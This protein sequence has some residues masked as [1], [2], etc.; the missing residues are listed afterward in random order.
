[1]SIHGIIGQAIIKSAPGRSIIALPPGRIAPRIRYNGSQLPGPGICSTG[2]DL[3]PGHSGTARHFQR[4][5]CFINNNTIRHRHAT[6]HYHR[7]TTGLIRSIRAGRSAIYNFH[8]FRRTGRHARLLPF[9]HNHLISPLTAFRYSIRCHHLLAIQFLLFI[10]R[11][12]LIWLQQISL[13][14]N[15]LRHAQVSAALSAQSFQPLF[16]LNSALHLLQRSTGLGSSFRTIRYRPAQQSTADP[17]IPRSGQPPQ[18]PGRFR[19]RSPIHLAGT[20]LRASGH[21]QLRIAGPA[22]RLPLAQASSIAIHIRLPVYSARQSLPGIGFVCRQQFQACTVICRPATGPLT[23][24][25]PA[26]PLRHRAHHATS[27]H[28]GHRDQIVHFLA[29]FLSAGHS[30]RPGW[31]G[32]QAITGNYR[33]V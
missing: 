10:N 27:G 32:W 7:T 23:T 5:Q 15:S 12:A 2:L 28:P 16:Q 4:R 6:G 25:Q 24:I 30:G 14:Y 11:I 19:V 26:Q 1:M 17:P 8:H 20:A 18:A 31:P 9:A 22:A 33:Q 29:S 21:G 3:A 13:F